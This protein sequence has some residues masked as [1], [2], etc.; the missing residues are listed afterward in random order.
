MLWLIKP[1]RPGGR[2][3]GP[4]LTAGRVLVEAGRLFQRHNALGSAGAIAFYTLF[5]LSPI[6]I[7]ITTGVGIVI[8][9]EVAEARVVDR[10]QAFVGPEAAQTARQIVSNTRIEHAGW[11]PTVAGVVAMIVGATAVLVQLQRSLNAIWGVDQT[12]RGQAVVEGIRNRLVALS[13][14]GLFGLGLLLSLI[15]SVVL[16]AVAR[17]AGDWLPVHAGV[18]APLENLVTLALMTGLFAA[19]FRMLPNVRLRWRDVLAGSLL[20]GLLFM[21]GRHL[22][23][24]YLAI[25]APG[26]AYGAAGSLVVLLVWIY[27]SALIML[28]GATL[29]RAIHTVRG[30]AIVPR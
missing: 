23:A 20:T 8:G 12:V 30:G 13:I 16:Q 5:S 9:P 3:I 29:T 4:F 14:V 10:L 15:S 6:F 18:L 27:G 19:V 26:S 28:F 1:L 24:T 21:P 11:L 25:A 22:L 7:L 17:F 2:Q